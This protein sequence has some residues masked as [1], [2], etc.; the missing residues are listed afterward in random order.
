MSKYSTSILTKLMAVATLDPEESFQIESCVRGHH[1][2]KATWT[3][4]L[5]QFREVQPESGNSHDAYVIAT[6]LDDT[7]VGHLPCEFSRVAFY[8]IQCGGRITCKNT[9]RRKFSSV[10]SKGLVIPCKYTFGGKPAMVKK[11]VKVICDKIDC[12]TQLASYKL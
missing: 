12:M 3:P 7:V 4:L 8:F 6:L 11:L 10:P 1:I 2:F 5:G 9:G